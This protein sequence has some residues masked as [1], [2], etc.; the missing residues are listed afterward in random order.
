MIEKRI[1][2]GISG[3]DRLIGGGFEAGSSILLSGS[4][5][6]GK[7]VFALQFAHA[8][9]SSGEPAL[10]VS[11]EE[12]AEDIQR[13]FESIGMNCRGLEESGKLKLL[14]L[15]PLVPKAAERLVEENAKSI[16]TKRV[17]VDSLTAFCVR[18]EKQ[19]EIRSAVFGLV[20]K[21]KE[22]GVSSLLTSHTGGLDSGV[23]DFIS[24]CV[25]DLSYENLGTQFARTLSI[26]KMRRS[27]HS[28]DVHPIAIDKNGMRVA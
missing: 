23:S 1:K 17:V 8:G 27:A 16:G 25:I 19:Q 6:T 28:M 18:F 4:C 20:S 15:N 3:L 26:R 13:D 5:G 10:Y 14:V 21:L 11:F 22:L 24:D 9:A 2:S 7:T 12:S